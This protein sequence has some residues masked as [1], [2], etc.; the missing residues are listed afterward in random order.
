VEETGVTVSCGV[1][2]SPDH[3]VDADNLMLLAD[4]ALYQAK[5]NGRNRVEKAGVKD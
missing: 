1:A 2:A 3:A 4:K 5:Q